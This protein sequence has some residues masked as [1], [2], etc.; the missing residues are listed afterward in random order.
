MS[1]TGF[2]DRV[3]GTRPPVAE[4]HPMSQY[5]AYIEKA[6]AA[7]GGHLSIGRGG[8][9]LRYGLGWLSGYDCETVK[10][11]AIAA[12]LPVCDSRKLDFDVVVKL[13]FRGPMIAV[14]RKP[15]AEP[16]NSLSFAPLYTVMEAYRRA[17]A[18]V[19]HM[20]PVPVAQD[21]AE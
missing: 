2:S 18:E 12:G 8:F 20:P 6:L 7:E 14:A 13:A 19:H 17:G 10:A 9:S 3:K 11:E 4:P 16:W 1:V 5:T 15:D 21:A